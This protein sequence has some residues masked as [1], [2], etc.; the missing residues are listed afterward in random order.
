MEQLESRLSNEILRR[1]EERSRL[2]ARLAQMDEDEDEDSLLKEVDAEI[3]RIPL[4]A[5]DETAET[6]AEELLRTEKE[7]EKV[8]EQVTINELAP[9]SRFTQ[10]RDEIQN[11]LK[12]IIGLE[13]ELVNRDIQLS[14]V[15]E[16]LSQVKVRK[17]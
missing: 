9:D 11:R 10:A 12:D 15:R 2:E 1:D 14:S 7:L 17:R 13:S 16:E 5:L 8:L 3:S 4:E 6:E